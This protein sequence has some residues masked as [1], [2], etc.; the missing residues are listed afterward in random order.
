MGW[1][2]GMHE[3]RRGW[4][5]EGL[6][7]GG[8][9]RGRGWEEEEGEGLEG[10]GAG[11]EEEEE[12]LRGKAGRKRGGGSWETPFPCRYTWCASLNPP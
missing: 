1:E 10:G 12:G 8:T 3:E 4:E 11:H 9:G 7:G 6:G 5:E 2:L